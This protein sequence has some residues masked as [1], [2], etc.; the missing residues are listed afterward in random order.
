[1]KRFHMMDMS[2]AGKF[3]DA[4]MA[5]A[6]PTMNATFWPLKRMPSADGGD[7]E[8]DGRDLRGLDLLL[9]GRAGRA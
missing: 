7:A 5:N 8:D 4:A 3:A 6:R 2:S 9:L 1:M